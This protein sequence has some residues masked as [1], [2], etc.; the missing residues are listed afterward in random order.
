MNQAD[1]GRELVGLLFRK[2][3]KLQTLIYLFSGVTLSANP[4]L[5]IAFFPY[6]HSPPTD[7]TL[8]LAPD[9]EIYAF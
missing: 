6:L 5:M 9:P 7:R 2:E 3:K 4:V 8:F 1:K